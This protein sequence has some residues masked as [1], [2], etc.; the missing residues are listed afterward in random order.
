[1]PMSVSGPTPN[2]S[3]VAVPPVIAPLMLLAAELVTDRLLVT[4]IAAAVRPPVVT[5]RLASGPPTAPMKAVLPDVLVVRATAL[6]VTVDPKE[7]LPP[8]VDDRLV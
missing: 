1:M 6:P 3:K 7:R 4:A 2:L 8:A 5:L